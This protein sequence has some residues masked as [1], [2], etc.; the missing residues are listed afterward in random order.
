MPPKNPKRV[1]KAV[2]ERAQRRAKAQQI[3][4]KAEAQQIL[5]K[6][7][8][9]QILIKAN[10]LAVQE[11]LDQRGIGAFR[12]LA[13]V[14]EMIFE[15]TTSLGARL[16][17]A[18]KMLELAIDNTELDT[19]S[20]ASMM[21]A[22]LL[23]SPKQGGLWPAFGLLRDDYSLIHGTDMSIP[24][25][26]GIGVAVAVGM[27]GANV[28]FQE[29]YDRM[30]VKTVGDLR[31]QV[32]EIVIDPTRRML[33]SYEQLTERFSRG[34]NAIWRMF[35]DLLKSANRSQQSARETL[36]YA[37]GVVST[38]ITQKAHDILMPATARTASVKAEI[39]QI[40]TRTESVRAK[41]ARFTAIDERYGEPTT[42]E[43]YLLRGM[44]AAVVVVGAA[45][46]AYQYG[47][48][49]AAPGVAELAPD[50]TG[51]YEY[52]TTLLTDAIY[53]KQ[54]DPEPIVGLG[55]YSWYGWG[56]SA[57]RNI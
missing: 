26:A 44:A 29:L 56:G 50:T 49:V 23:A 13:R 19:V 55:E 51:I 8:A 16:V 11:G 31:A 22:I 40:A 53:G 18:G 57:G 41:I 21:L 48:A 10:S 47:P 38:V 24:K 1:S 54:P 14:G 32:N 30:G 9:Q 37:L 45:G 28:G 36:G 46:L 17:E 33:L 34:G 4:T 2:R 20:R 3:L 52:L 25:A 6:A 7:E 5:T 39:G 12:P 15:G 42:T 35:A 27:A 43:G